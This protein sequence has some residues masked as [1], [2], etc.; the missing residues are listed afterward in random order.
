MMAYTSLNTD[1]FSWMAERDEN[2]IT[3][4]VTC[5]RRVDDGSRNYFGS[6]QR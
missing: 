1:C 5:L 2:I 4:I 3:A 6:V